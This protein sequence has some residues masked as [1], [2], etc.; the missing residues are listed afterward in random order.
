[1]QKRAEHGV[2][3]L[4]AV[5]F[6][7]FTVL[8]LN[9]YRLALKNDYIYSTAESSFIT[10]NAGESQGTIYDRNLQPL[11]NEETE[12]IAAVVPG[13][14]D[15]NELA[16]LAK[17][18]AELYVK[19]LNGEPFTIRCIKKGKESAAVTFFEIPLRYSEHQTA[20]HIVGYLSENSG[21]S[22]IEHA[23]D[24]IL[25]E[26]NISNTVTYS[27]DGFGNILIGGGK[28]VVR[29]SKPL[30]G[31]VTT[32]DKDIQKICEDCA[33]KKG[34]VIVT[35]V[36]T[37]EILGLASFPSYSWNNID[38][39][40]ENEDSPLIN[41]ALYS[42]SVGSIFKLVTALEGLNE[43]FSGFVYSCEGEIDI[44]GQGFR[45]HKADGH[46][47]QNMTEAMTNSC[48]TYFIC[49][50]R[51]FDVASFRQLAFDLGFG[52]EIHLC[53]GMTGAS[54]VL[55]TAEQLMIPAE[56]A[57]FSFGQ[58]KLTAT[59]LQINQLTAAIANG[60]ELVLSSLIKGVTV[61]GKAIGNEKLPQ[62]TRV[63]SEE[64]SDELRKMM[65]AAVYK[66]KNSNAKPKN[67]LAAAKTST[68]QT[69]RFDDEGEEE[70]NAWITGFFPANK[71]VYAVTVLVEDGGY[72]NDTA[73]PIFSNI[74]DSI[75]KLK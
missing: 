48:N 46:G 11:V 28:S 1:M 22:G 47:L 27:T 69:G 13:E 25:R 23:Y 56:L 30:T 70:C 29:S 37:G 26:G 57:N 72:G 10:L 71:P 33:I 67:T 62:S 8:G 73:A 45:C 2:I 61:D 75:T 19:Y 12:I 54:G 35:D 43:G 42:Y 39:A 68:A 65:K 50:S 53:A 24:R 4:T 9:Y 20:Q 52:R 49:M 60:G 74:I 16:E 51:N 66:N 6:L 14:T 21:V 41:R 38:A 15:I 18:K 7:L 64:A 40:L 63:M 36:K 58:G 32:L 5:F 34:A 17:N 3:A 31:V 44:S 55:P 59:P